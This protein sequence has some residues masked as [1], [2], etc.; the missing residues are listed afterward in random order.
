MRACWFAIILF[1]YVLPDLPARPLVVAYERFHRDLPTA[2]GGAILYAELG[3][4][5]CHGGGTGSGP[6]LVD[7]S[8]RVRH[9]WVR[10]FLTD[11]SHGRTGSTMPSFLS[12][13]AENESMA[14][15]EAIVAYL[16]TL[17]GKAKIKRGRHVNAERGSALYHEI[18]C[19]ACHAPTSDFHPSSPE[20]IGPEH[21]VVLPDLA[22]KTAL[23][24]LADFLL[25]TDTYRPS[26]RMPQFPIEEQDALDIAAH[27]LDHQGS[28]PREVPAIP[29]WPKADA[30]E[31]ARGRALVA[32][33]RCASCHDLPGLGKP[34][35]IPLPETDWKPGNCLTQLPYSGLPSYGLGPDQIA[36]LDAFLSA[37]RHQ[38]KESDIAVH[39]LNCIACHEQHGR[40]G[41]DNFSRPFFRGDDS[42]GDSGRLPPPLTHVGRKLRRDWLEGVL[43]GRPE[44]RA[45]PYLKTRMP[46]YRAQAEQLV[47]VLSEPDEPP[48]PA[49][50]ELL[51]PGRKLLG[52]QGGANCLTCHRWGERDSFGIQ[53]I[54]LSLQSARLHPEWFHN[55]LL[56]PAAYRPGTLMPAFWPDGKSSLPGILGGDTDQQ[57]AAIWEFLSR[58]VGL[59]EGFP[60]L[61]TGRFELV[62]EDRPII[63]RTF[64]EGVGTKAILVGF[65][66]GLNLAYDAD[67][68]RPALLWRGR[69]FDAY[70]TWFLRKAPFQ[71]PLG[72]KP[73]PFEYFHTQEKPY[74]FLGY[75][76]DAA[77]NPTFLIESDGRRVTDHYAVNDGKIV[78]TL[79]ESEG[80]FPHMGSPTGLRSQK[81]SGGGKKIL[82]TIIGKDGKPQARPATTTSI[83]TSTYELP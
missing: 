14:R 29:R 40:G 57:I 20:A 80:I 60:D 42:L 15:A 12:F 9:D 22:T 79:D 35:V 49:R 59:P 64:L 31:V 19:V 62:P 1:A 4:A 13:L 48:A 6:S 32:E 65:P 41:P 76:I 61:A 10:A 38:M 27:L 23:S 55:F 69:F 74:R 73:I 43:L 68:A 16:G 54:D 81:D 53:G 36:A 39:G 33:F 58:G 24:E 83:S 30:E 18:G 71:R 56:D 50:P 21:P 17:E 45:R 7:I 11:P 51:E 46:V 26:A 77:G 2:E 78:R 34:A 63:Q 70:E 8:K 66:G 82:R 67:K 3:C 44:N 47:A 75:T 52:F 5:N 28:D 37:G 25:K 72:E